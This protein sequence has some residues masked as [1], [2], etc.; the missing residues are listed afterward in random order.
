MTH[1]PRLK[2]AKSINEH[3]I[4]ELAKSGEMANIGQFKFHVINA[5]M[6]DLP[7]FASRLFIIPAPKHAATHI[8]LKK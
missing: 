3:S 1:D 7:F 4:K 5:M 6:I 2:L 8:S